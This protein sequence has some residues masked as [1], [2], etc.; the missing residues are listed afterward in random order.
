MRDTNTIDALR[1]ALAKQ[2]PDMERGFTIQTSYGELKI[3]AEDA[4]HFAALARVILG[5]KLA[6]MEVSHD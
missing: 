6:A 4:D 2:V 1:Y 3:D 5:D